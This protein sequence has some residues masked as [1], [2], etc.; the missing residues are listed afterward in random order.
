MDSKK[1][2]NL[3]DDLAQ[4]DDESIRLEFAKKKEDAYKKLMQPAA[5]TP[6]PL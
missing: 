5:P 1:C 3:A 2:F 4:E 6:P